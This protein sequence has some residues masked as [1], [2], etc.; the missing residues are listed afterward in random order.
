MP[1]VADKI[2]LAGDYV[3][4]RHWS[5]TGSNVQRLA[6]SA[7]LAPWPKFRLGVGIASALIAGSQISDMLEAV[8][9][10]IVTLNEVAQDRGIP[11]ELDF[12]P[13]IGGIFQFVARGI[14][15]ELDPA[16]QVR[17]FRQAFSSLKQGDINGMKNQLIQLGRSVF[18]DY[19]HMV[20]VKFNWVGA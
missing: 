13:D 3:E 15:L 14:A 18:D 8:N 11:V 4:A 2:D 5:I 7:V 17:Q 6:I 12:E 9:A 16:G 19:G 1:G 10:H 20:R